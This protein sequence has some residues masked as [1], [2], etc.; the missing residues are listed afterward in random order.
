[1]T[2]FDHLERQL[3]ERVAERASLTGEAASPKRRGSRIGREARGDQGASWQSAT[4]RRPLMRLGVAA[5]AASAAALAGTVLTTGA[6]HLSIVA[7]AYAA[8]DANDHVVHYVEVADMAL[9]APSRRSLAAN[10]RHAAIW[11]RTEVWIYRDSSRRVDTIHGLRFKGH[12]GVMV[13][14]ETSDIPSGDTLRQDSGATARRYLAGA[15]LVMKPPADVS[16]PCPGIT[17]CAFSTPHPIETLRRLYRRG[18]L[19]DDGATTLRGRRLDMIASNGGP[20]LRVLVDPKTFAPVR[21]VSEAASAS[22]RPLVI[23]A[24]IEDYTQLPPDGHTLGLLK[25]RSHPKAKVIHWPR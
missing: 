23:K 7:R 6:G 12:H 16:L 3:L 10:P 8:T 14:E 18:K 21:L 9:E 25:M 11:R 1:M 2:G 22:G 19:E 5:L 17:N 20:Y 4:R 15:L 24:E 13:S